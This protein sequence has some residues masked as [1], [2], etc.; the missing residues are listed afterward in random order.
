MGRKVR[1]VSHGVEW[2][3]GMVSLA[4]GCGDGEN[5][6]DATRPDVNVDTGHGATV[7]AMIPHITASTSVTAAGEV[8]YEVDLAATSTMKD[9]D[10]DPGDYP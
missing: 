10:A 3:N 4:T 8:A 5:V 6:R 7:C 9:R 1:S 2:G